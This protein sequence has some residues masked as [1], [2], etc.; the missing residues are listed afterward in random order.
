MINFIKKIRANTKITKLSTYFSLLVFI[1]G[2]VLLIFRAL[3]GPTPNLSLLTTFFY[4]TSQSNILILVVTLLF[5]TGFSSKKWFKYLAYIALVNIFMTGIIFHI[6]LTPYMSIVTFTNQMLHTV[7]PIL[8]FYIYYIIFKDHIQLKSI[9]V[10]L[11]YPLFYM[12]FVYIFI[13][14]FFGDLL[15]QLLPNFTGARYVYPFLD[16]RIY[17][18]GITGLLLFNLGFLAPTIFLFALLLAFLKRKIENK[19]A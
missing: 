6:F 18:N 1:F 8:Y 4:F 14:P 16:P 3:N 5:V 9:W 19:V 15:D 2:I 17:D 12:I 10:S 11:I 13:E 7:N